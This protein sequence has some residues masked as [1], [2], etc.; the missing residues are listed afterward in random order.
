MLIHSM[1]SVTWPRFSF[2][3]L[4]DPASST[5]STKSAVDIPRLADTAAIADL[6]YQEN[7]SY[8]PTAMEAK[9][10]EGLKESST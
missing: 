2:S 8:E 3:V 7:I 6:I 1:S 4:L 9:G 10:E 5:P